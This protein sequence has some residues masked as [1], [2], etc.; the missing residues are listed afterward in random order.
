MSEQTVSHGPNGRTRGPRSRTRAVALALCAAL[1][2]ASVASV[3]VETEG[4]VPPDRRSEPPAELL[5]AN[6]PIVTLRAEVFGASP[7]QRVESITERIDA[8]LEK[9]GGIPVATMLDT[10]GGFVVM[11][12]GVPVFRVLDEDVDPE[13]NQT[14]RELASETTTRFGQALAEVAEARN[15]RALL[16]AVGWSM[17]ATLLLAVVVWALA[18]AYRWSSRRVR[19]A[20]E[21]HIRHYTGWRGLLLGAAGP[22][23]FVIVPLRVAN[24]LVGLLCTYVWAG[25][26]LR[27]FPFTRPW[28][29]ALRENLLDA[30]GQFGKSIL[31]A[32][33]GLLFVVLIFFLAR[34]AVRVVRA[35]FEA[36]HSRRLQLGWIDETTARP[37]GQLISWAIWLFAL[38]AA[39][40][41][42]PGSD[43][44]AFKGVGVF[45]GL[46]LS[47][48]SSGIVNQAV[49]GLMLMYTR[50][51]RPGEFVQI[52]ETEGT[53]TSVGFVTTRIE[54]LRHE[55]VSIPNAVIAANVTRNFSRLAPEGGVRIA[56]RVNIGY[57]TP[58]RQV[59]AMLRLA[60]ARTAGI[61]P[62]S[63]PRV[64]QTALHDFY[65]EYTLLVPITDPARRAVVLSELHAN[66]QDV[67]NE[68]GVQIMTP[69]YEADP[70]QPKVVA[71]ADWFR[72]PA[73]SADAELEASPAGGSAAS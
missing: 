36:A 14:T 63:E 7:A 1:D 26:V 48:G 31:H 13:L 72:S 49:S 51:L 37:T 21:R 53:V 6:R 47:I 39:Y 55:E 2:F 58:W 69:N 60:A 71:S 56:T 64:L 5:V 45:V 12:N 24:W 27:R 10:P 34:V 17:L 70:A 67:F 16:P 42:I 46:M 40:P 62:Q 28:G 44:E 68:N 65:V 18:G 50:A 29:E 73:R 54:T 66:I 20:F 11:M 41:Y 32:I 4:A 30:L 33:P 59:H 61:A 22:A 38:V 3:A 25:F 52:G 35:L 9:G 57:D 15:A 8:L 19:A 23:P 43:S